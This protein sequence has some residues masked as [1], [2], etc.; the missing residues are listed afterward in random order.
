MAEPTQVPKANHSGVPKLGLSRIQCAASLGVSPRK[1]DEL[2]A[3]RRG[4]TFPVAYI[5]SKPIV[6]VH[7]LRDWLA[8]QAQKKGGS[9]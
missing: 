8:E 6:P 2:I 5:G 3:G 7:L 1:V 4:N 9:P